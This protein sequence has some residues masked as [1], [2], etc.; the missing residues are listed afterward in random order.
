MW[1]AFWR[2]SG[3]R[4]ARDRLVC[5]GRPCE[6]TNL[7][8]AYADGKLSSKRIDSP[9]AI[10]GCAGASPPQP[11]LSLEVSGGKGSFICASRE[12][13]RPPGSAPLPS[14][15]FFGGRGG[16]KSNSCGTPVGHQLATQGKKWALWIRGLESGLPL[17]LHCRLSLTFGPSRLKIPG[18]KACG[19]DSRSGH[20]RQSARQIAPSARSLRCP[21]D[22]EQPVV[23]DGHA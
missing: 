18:R 6:N 3:D 15:W 12:R 17:G 21:V 23:A 4:L 11:S 9:L 1:R 8:P 10:A 16:G 14:L 20:I 19:F 5:N 2:S 22:R 7:V 13:K